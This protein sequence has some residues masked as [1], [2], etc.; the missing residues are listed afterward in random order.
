MINSFEEK[1]YFAFTTITDTAIIKIHT[2]TSP[3]DTISL[4]YI[5]KFENIFNTAVSV[6]L[7]PKTD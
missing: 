2:T 7:K 3:T 6:S 5:T 1:S 4:G